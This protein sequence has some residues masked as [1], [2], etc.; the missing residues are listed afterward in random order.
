MV[1]LDDMSLAEAV[2]EFN[3]YNRLQLRLGDTRV[4][5]LRLGGA[6]DFTKPLA[7]AA[8]LQA[9]GCQIQPARD[10]LVLISSCGASAQDAASQH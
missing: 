8:S 3:R 9:L 5:Q 4:G 1:L 2:L 7:F 6:F 10:H